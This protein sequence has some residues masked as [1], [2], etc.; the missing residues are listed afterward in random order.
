[1]EA[2]MAA[3]L[4]FDDIKK[5]IRSYAIHQHLYNMP[6]AV[7]RQFNGMM[8]AKNYNGSMKYW[9]EYLENTDQEPPQFPKLTND[10]DYEK[11]YA[12]FQAAFENMSENRG[13]LVDKGKEDTTLAFLDKWYGPGKLF[14]RK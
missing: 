7:R 8:E 12:M 1:M 4:Q 13:D 14:Q 2:V 10:S 6:P 5:F 9:P 3:D 11:L